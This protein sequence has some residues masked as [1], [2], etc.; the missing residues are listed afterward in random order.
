MIS[1][2]LFQD[3]HRELRRGISIC[4]FAQA[5]KPMKTIRLSNRFTAITG[6]AERDG[7]EV[8]PETW[9]GFNLE[10]YYLKDHPWNISRMIHSMKK[11]LDYYIENFGPYK[12]KQARIVEFPRVA[13]YAAAFPGTMPYSKS[14]GFIFNLNHPDDIDQ[15]FYVVAHET[16]HQW[17]NEQVIGA[18]MEGATLLSELSESLA[19]YSSLMVMEKELGRDRM[20]KFLKYEMDQYLSARGREQLRERPLWKVEYKQFYVFYKKA[21]VAF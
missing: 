20:R 10:V 6:R 21:A 18:N 13:T 15:V 14:F 17:W 12:H 19:Q 1:R 9:N 11:S 2:L 3:E 7:H 4:F 8:A 5:T 16:A